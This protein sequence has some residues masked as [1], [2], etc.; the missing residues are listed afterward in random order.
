[1][2]GLG[3]YGFVIFLYLMFDIIKSCGVFVVVIGSVCWW[4]FNWIDVL[5][6]VG[7]LM[8][9]GVRVLCR[10]WIY[11]FLVIDIVVDWYGWWY[12]GGV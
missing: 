10:G 11:D 7:F 4:W 12:C 1:M 8:G 9:C 3:C 5:G 6:K 2:W